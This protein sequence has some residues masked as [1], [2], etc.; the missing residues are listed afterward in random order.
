MTL[1]SYTSDACT[2]M[3]FEA[4][5]PTPGIA[6]GGPL[7]PQ[8]DPLVGFCKLLQTTASQGAG[9]GRG[10]PPH[11]SGLSSCGKTLRHWALPSAILSQ[12]QP[13]LSR[14]PLGRPQGP[15]PRSV[16]RRS[17]VAEIPWRAI[18]PG[19]AANVFEAAVG[20]WI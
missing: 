20:L 4:R 18:L 15:P 1:P 9:R 17:R 8:A 19:A 16:P 11:S 3:L 12:L 5:S 2:Q 14:V 7:G 13:R 10:R 6:I